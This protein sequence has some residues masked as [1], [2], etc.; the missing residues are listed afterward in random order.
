M[1]KRLLSLLLILGLLLT[2]LP[3]AVAQ[4]SDAQTIVSF[5]RL[6]LETPV[7]EP[8]DAAQERVVWFILAEDYTDAAESCHLLVDYITG[9]NDDDSPMVQTQSLTRCDLHLRKITC[10]ENGRQSTRLMCWF[11][12]NRCCAPDR[13]EIAAG[14]F[15]RA[16]GGV[17]PALS[18]DDFPFLFFDRPF[19][20]RSRVL[21]ETDRL[22]ASTAVGEH[23]PILFDTQLPV[24]VSF[25][26][27]GVKVADRDAMETGES[28]LDAGAAGTHTLEI[29][30]ED[31]PLLRQTVAVT[32]QKQVYSRTM[33]ELWDEAKYLPLLPLVSPL[34]FIIAP[35]AGIAAALSPLVA[36]EA[37][38]TMLR[39]FFRIFNLLKH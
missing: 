13:V 25:W 10:R 27:D 6:C 36:G 12:E 4:K 20:R 32:A 39:Y 28:R 38:G 9:R 8:L 34:A 18:F 24:P 37:F 3:L 2:T 14:S 23:D 19:S 35:P 1:K 16:D 21:E 17:C 22:S 33:R 31:Y 26:Y 11:P 30:F 7:V 5:G 29:R 15:V